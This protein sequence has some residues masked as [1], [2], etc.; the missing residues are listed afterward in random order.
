MCQ[1][2]RA[3]TAP[4]RAPARAP[5]ADVEDVRDA[6]AVGGRTAK[7]FVP[8][9]S[10]GR[11]CV[12]QN[13]ARLNLT[14]TLAQLYGCFSF[15]LAEE[16]RRAALEPRRALLPACLCTEHEHE[17]PSLCEPVRHT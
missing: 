4:E 1:R 17:H 11:D 6:P 12:G 5:Q 7:R 9:S 16:V 3:A 13:L 2:R 10:G 8:F 15:R 14:T